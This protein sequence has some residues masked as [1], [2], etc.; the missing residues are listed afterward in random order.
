MC[1]GRFDALGGLGLCGNHWKYKVNLACKI[2][3]NSKTK[4]F[5]LRL[6]SLFSLLCLVLWGFLC[7][8][9]PRE[10]AI[11]DNG[12]EDRVYQ[13]KSCA[14]GNIEGSMT[15]YGSLSCHSLATRLLFQWC[16]NFLPFP[17]LRLALGIYIDIYTYVLIYS[18]ISNPPVA[19]FIQTRPRDDICDKSKREKKELY[20]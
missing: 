11:N 13:F 5:P 9:S 16:P 4:T 15:V 19:C 14:V 2:W 20:T 8:E 10:G 3:A 18:L 17:I 7:V 6:S 1:W 12:R